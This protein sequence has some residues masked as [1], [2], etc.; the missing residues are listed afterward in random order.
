MEHDDTPLDKVVM[1]A[2]TPEALDRCCTSRKALATA[3]LLRR[4]QSD[5]EPGVLG[6]RPSRRLREQRP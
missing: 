1:R 5:S 3:G 6:A 2:S 4:A